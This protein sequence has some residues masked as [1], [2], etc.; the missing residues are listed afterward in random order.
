MG[1][2]ELSMKGSLSQVHN[3]VTV[4]VRRMMGGQCHCKDQGG[5]SLSL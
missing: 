4:T 3:G 2:T 5:G 1:V